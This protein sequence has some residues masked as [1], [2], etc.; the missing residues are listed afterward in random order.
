MENYNKNTM[1]ALNPSECKK[2]VQTRNM[3]NP[4]ELKNIRKMLKDY[5]KDGTK[6]LED[7]IIHLNKLYDK[8]H[9]LGDSDFEL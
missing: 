3:E 4:Q 6:D 5:F 1:I 7:I 2:L 8:Y 9:Q